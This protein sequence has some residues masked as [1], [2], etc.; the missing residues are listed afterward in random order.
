M[1]NE[2]LLNCF[3][4]LPEDWIDGG[5]TQELTDIKTPTQAPTVFEWAESETVRWPHFLSKSLELNI[6]SHTTAQLFPG[7]SFGLKESL[8][9]P[10]TSPVQVQHSPLNEAGQQKPFVVVLVDGAQF[11]CSVGGSIP[12]EISFVVI[13]ICWAG[14]NE[15]SP[16]LGWL[17][18]H[19]ITLLAPNKHSCRGRQ[20]NN[21]T[22][23]NNTNKLN[24]QSRTASLAWL[25][26]F[27]CQ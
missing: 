2:E 19:L 5:E 26:L 25:A 20:G 23:D 6:Q 16:L 21:T 9:A 22:I 13:F 15:H 3:V 14:G 18:N 12:L 4:E 10:F 1:K 11:P 24:S 17:V 8:F 27:S 7:R